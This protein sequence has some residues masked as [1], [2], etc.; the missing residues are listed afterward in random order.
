MR[1]A[2]VTVAERE[3]GEPMALPNVDRERVLAALDL[4]QDG[5]IVDSSTWYCPRPSVHF[6]S[7]ARERYV[8]HHHRS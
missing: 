6:F 7:V 4:L 3:P 5:R 2:P 1:R 8:L